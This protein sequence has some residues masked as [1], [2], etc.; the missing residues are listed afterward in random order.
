MFDV[1]EYAKLPLIP[2][3]LK[4]GN[5]EFWYGVNFAS[6]GGGALAESN[7]GM[8]CNICVLLIISMFMFFCYGL[9]IRS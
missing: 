2:P 5:H 8:V 4:P 6:A 7:Q 1:A 3:Y 9:V